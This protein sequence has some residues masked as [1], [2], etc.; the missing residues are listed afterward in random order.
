M[1]RIEAE[2]RDALTQAVADPTRNLGV[3]AAILIERG[4]ALS[5][6]PARAQ[7]VA[8]D[9]I[10]IGAHGQDFLQDVLL[11]S[12]TSRLLRKSRCSVLIVKQPPP[13]ETEAAADE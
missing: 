12:T 7:S 13:P 1:Q 3:S 8:T 5:A 10:L 6:V 2:A 9:L 11:G 4:L